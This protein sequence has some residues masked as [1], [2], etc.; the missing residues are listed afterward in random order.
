MIVV[1]VLGSIYNQTSNES[2]NF[3]SNL[4]EYVQVCCHRYMPNRE[5][6]RANMYHI[7]KLKVT[8]KNALNKS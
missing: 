1:K 5:F 2:V 4:N 7:S 3:I 6:F 8:F